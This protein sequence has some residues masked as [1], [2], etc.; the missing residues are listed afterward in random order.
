MN[1]NQLANALKPSFLPGE[2]LHVKVM[3]EGKEPGQGVAF[4]DDGTMVVVEGGGKHVEEEL[5]VT[6]TRILQ[7][8][9]GRMIFA[10]MA[11]A[12]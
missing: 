8:V 5:E 6:V 11:A 2:G 7:T 4:L 10:E 12:S 9:A 3:Q 1:L